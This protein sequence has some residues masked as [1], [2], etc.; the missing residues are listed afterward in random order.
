M[1]IPFV[2]RANDLA[3]PNDYRDVMGEVLER[4]FGVGNMKKVFP[5]HKYPRIGAFRYVPSG[6]TDQDTAKARTR[7]SRS[8]WHPAQV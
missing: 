1:T 8:S 5:D 7:Y 4:R 2:A 3:G 6:H